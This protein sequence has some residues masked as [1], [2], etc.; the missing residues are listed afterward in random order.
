VNGFNGDVVLG[1]PQ[2]SPQVSYV[3]SHNELQRQQEHLD[4]LLLGWFGRQRTSKAPSRRYS[5]AVTYREQAAVLLTTDGAEPG[6]VA[7]FWLHRDS[8][9]PLAVGY[10]RERGSYEEIDPGASAPAL[11]RL[12]QLFLDRR[13]TS[14]FSLPSR[15]QH[16]RADRLRSEWKVDHVEVNGPV[17]ASLFQPPR[18]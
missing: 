10:E 18:R 12:E 1:V 5:G 14:G 7:R 11:I 17:D 3:P 15:I 6:F 8:C 16:V 9:L 2:V 4:Q 13:T